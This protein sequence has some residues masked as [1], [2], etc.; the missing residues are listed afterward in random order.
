MI[1]C[2]LHEG[3]FLLVSLFVK[4]DIIDGSSYKV[5]DIA[6][7]KCFIINILLNLLINYKTIVFWSYK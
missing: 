4:I 3:H 6:I 7:Q 2:P 1:V 5:F